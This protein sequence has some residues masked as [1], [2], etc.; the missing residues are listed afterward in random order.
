MCDART[1][2]RPTPSSPSLKRQSTMATWS[3][4]T[5]MANAAVEIS[6]LNAMGVSIPLQLESL[7][8]QPSSR[9]RRLIKASQ[10]LLASRAC[11]YCRSAVAA[12]VDAV[13]VT[14][15]QTAI[16]RQQRRAERRDLAAVER[17]RRVRPARARRRR[18]AEPADGIPRRLRRDDA[19]R[20]GPRVRHRTDA[21]SSATSRGRDADSPSRLD[22]AC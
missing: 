2:A 16:A 14:D 1:P 17:R 8:H 9:T 11:R 6:V 21:A 4:S 5:C 3:S 18:R 15:A 12:R 7:R 19:L 13:A 10:M 22:C 20:Q